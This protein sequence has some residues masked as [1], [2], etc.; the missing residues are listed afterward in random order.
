MPTRKIVLLV[1]AWNIQW[2]Y[3]LFYGPPKRHKRKNTKAVQ[4]RIFSVRGVVHKFA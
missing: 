2:C 1:K 4:G 3:I